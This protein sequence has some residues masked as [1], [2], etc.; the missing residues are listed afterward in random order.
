[1]DDN[2]SRCAP[3]KSPRTL[4]NRR[5]IETSWDEARALPRLALKLYA[6]SGLYR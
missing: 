4:S 2:R 6:S 1:M 5:A 3:E